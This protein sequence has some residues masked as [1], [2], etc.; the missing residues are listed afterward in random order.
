MHKLFFLPEHTL[1][2]PL[3]LISF[4]PSLCW[5]PLHQTRPLCVLST[6]SSQLQTVSFTRAGSQR[7]CPL[8]GL[9]HCPHAW[10]ISVSHTCL[11]SGRMM[12][13]SIQ[14]LLLVTGL[15]QRFETKGLMVPNWKQLTC[16]STIE[17]INSH[18]LITAKRMYYV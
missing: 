14:L 12:L 3:C 9:R 10:H 7:P 16:P 6:H 1:S 5:F 4:K 17:Q 18:T 8:L 15:L 13:F 2:G 11:L